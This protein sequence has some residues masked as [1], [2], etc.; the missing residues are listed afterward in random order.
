[1]G[2][3]PVTVSFFDGDTLPE[4]G[5]NKVT[6]ILTYVTGQNANRDAVLRRIYADGLY[7]KS[8]VAILSISS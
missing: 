1:M 8:F 2:T 3:S 5:C 6:R 7:F 4:E